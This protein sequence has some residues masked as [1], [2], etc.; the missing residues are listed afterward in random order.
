VRLVLR[1]SVGMATL[2]ALAQA[3]VTYDWIGDLG[4]HCDYPEECIATWLPRVFALAEYLWIATVAAGSIALTAAGLMRRPRADI[5]AL[6]GAL[7][8]AFISY[9]LT[10]MV[11]T[12]PWKPI[13]DWHQVED[14][15]FFWGGPGYTLTSLL[16]AISGGL[17][18]WQILRS[19]SRG[20]GPNALAEDKQVVDATEG[21]H[22]GTA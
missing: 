21:G 7:A 16:M 20:E 13:A 19:M 15:A 14:N 5:A 17:L 10:P 6:G 2:T 18:G 12:T 22:R 8:T 1:L 4:D 3:W 9:C 11:Q